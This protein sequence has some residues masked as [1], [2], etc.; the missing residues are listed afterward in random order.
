MSPY[1]RN[2]MIGATVLGS[3]AVLIWMLVKFGGDVLKPFAP[4][5]IQIT[6]STTRA[7]GVAVGSQVYYR[8]VAVGKV[9]DV[10]RA[11]DNQGV[12]IVAEVESEPP[13]PGN[14]EAQ[15]R[16]T[17]LLGGNTGIN[18]ELIAG[19]APTGELT[20]GQPLKTTFVGLDVLP[21]EF[22]S[23][24]EELRL[25]SKQFRESG[26][27]NDLDEQI[28]KVGKTL[29]S[30]QTLLDDPRM[31]EDL[32]ATIANFRTASEKATT[33]ATNAEKFTADLPKLSEQASGTMTR[34]SDTIDKSSKRIDELSKSVGD[35]LSQ[36]ATTLDTI[37][38]IMVKVDKGD[39]TVGKL[40]NDP[41]LYKNLLETTEQLNASSADLKRLLEQWEQEGVSLRL[42]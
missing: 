27:V 31:R 39:G 12:A 14:V 19:E 22:A 36:V 9:I 24:A 21:R 11:A 37:Q 1:R 20:S 4:P 5:S 6:L 25:T 33:V 18:L 2:V 15:I 8:G 7:D 41:K 16:Q 32:K 26:V 35:R 29:D 23:L 3:L 13:L 34:A 10:K 40:I 30:V 28:N 17:N 42:N 38:S